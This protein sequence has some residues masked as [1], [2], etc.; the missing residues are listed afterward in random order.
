MA[1]TTAEKIAVM[2]A[3]LAGKPIEIT[4]AYHVKPWRGLTN[5]REPHWNWYESDYRVAKT[6][7][8]H[9]ALIHAYADGA[10]IELWDGAQWM[11]ISHPAFYPTYQYRVK[12]D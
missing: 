2:Q 7:H 9:A 4:D 10:E 6:P 11:K 12:S 3:Y 8:P 5:S 1:K